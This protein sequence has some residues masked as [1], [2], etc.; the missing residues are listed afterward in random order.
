MRILLVDDNETITSMLS[1]YL[2][3]KGYDVSVAND[4]QNGLN[5][6]K[7]G[8]YDSV[9]LDLSMP[10]FSGYDV[11]DALDAQ[12]LIQK[13]R[14]VVLT[15]SN[16]SNDKIDSLLALGIHMCMKKPMKL[17]ELLEALAG[18]KLIENTN[19]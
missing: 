11:I 17:K 10:D 13:N 7:T 1:K 16:I 5:L 4:G 9:L 18:E 15:A 14:I 12:N 19:R 3:L 8:S 6:I 2:S